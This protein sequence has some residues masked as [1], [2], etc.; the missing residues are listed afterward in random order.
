MC[1]E[2]AT[3][4]MQESRC[5]RRKECQYLRISVNVAVVLSGERQQSAVEECE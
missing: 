2:F 4:E 5:T 3:C 1:I